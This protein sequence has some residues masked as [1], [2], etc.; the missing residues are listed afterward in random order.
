M[1]QIT[2]RRD[3]GRLDR[4]GG[5]DGADRSVRRSVAGC[6]AGAEV[7]SLIALAGV[8]AVAGSGV[9]YF[10]DYVLDGGRAFLL[11]A[12]DLVGGDAVGAVAVGHEHVPRLEGQAL[13]RQRGGGQQLGRE[14]RVRRPRARPPRARPRQ[15][16]HQRRRVRYLTQTRKL[17]I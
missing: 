4:F 11:E 7:Q 17:Q 14:P 10:V 15:R 12:Y 8:P 16:Q 2:E 13:E 5:Q 6:V 1:T 3:L 9:L